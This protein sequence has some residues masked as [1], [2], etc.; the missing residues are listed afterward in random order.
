MA[1][2]AAVVFRDVYKRF[3][4]VLALEGVSLSVRRGE[5]VALLGPNGAGKSTSVALMLGLRGPSAGT[6]EVLGTDPT[7][8]VRRGRVAAV[9]QSG[10]LPPGL[11]VRELVD[12]TRRLYPHPLPLG[13]ALE[14]AGCAA[15]AGERVERLS[16]GQV[17]R[18]RYAMALVGC[19][20]LLFLD[21][22]TTGLDVDARR[23]FWESVRRR[24]AAGATVL[25]AT[26]YL[27]EADAAADRVVVLHRGRVVAD[28]TPGAIKA[29]VGVRALRFRCPRADREALRRLEAV[30]DAEVQG[31]AV[32]L[33]S[34]DVDAT[35]RALVRAEI[36]FRELE[37]GGADLEDAFL[38][39]VGD[40]GAREGEGR[41]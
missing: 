2:G 17:Q 21:E 29:R 20:E 13:E 33:R 6:V 18:V 16:G 24:A 11:R 10:G 37:I 31:E 34:V 19:P 32:R 1:E 14:E 4:A 15:F 3:G 39:L 40:E 30:A 7:V 28:G 35:V 8:A 26:H 5:L 36:P 38:A 22:A 25:F 41:P 23:R 9:L 12:F 27:D